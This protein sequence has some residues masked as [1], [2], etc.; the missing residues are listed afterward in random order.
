LADLLDKTPKFPLHDMDKQDEFKIYTY[1]KPK[2]FEVINE[3]NGIY[4]IEGEMVEKLIT[5][6]DFNNEEALLRFSRT[7]RNMG[8]DD[9]LREKG[10]KNG[11]RVY[12]GNFGFDFIDEE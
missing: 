4:H 7:M 10:C 1:E 5:N 9:A 11:D 3:G 8:I 2:N 6:L 12:I